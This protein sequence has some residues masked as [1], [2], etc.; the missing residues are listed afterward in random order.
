MLEWATDAGVPHVAVIAGQV[1]A[2]ARD[3]LALR[4]GVQLLALTDRVWQSGEA[5]ARAATLVE[6]AALEAG[7]RV[8]GGADE[9]RPR[10]RGRT[11]RGT[12]GR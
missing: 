5:F 11:S 6:E 10:A 7:R 2:E 4:A 9:L 1:T 3:E 12:P 8:L